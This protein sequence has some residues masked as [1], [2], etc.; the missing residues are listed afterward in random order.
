MLPT[1]QNRTSRRSWSTRATAIA[2]PRVFRSG[3]VRGANDL[4][5]AVMD[6]TLEGRDRPSRAAS[7][8]ASP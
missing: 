5:G 1:P 3:G 6:M 4:G 7:A 8:A 2:A